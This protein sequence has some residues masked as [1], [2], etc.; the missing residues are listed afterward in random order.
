MSSDYWLNRIGTAASVTTPSGSVPQYGLATDIGTAPW[1]DAQSFNTWVQ[2]GIERSR[3]Q[4]I[5]KLE[6]AKQ[7]AEAGWWQ[8]HAARA[9]KGLAYGVGQTGEDHGWLRAIPVVGT[10]LGAAADALFG[11]DDT[12]PEA[13]QA[14]IRRGAQRLESFSNAPG[15]KQFGQAWDFTSNVLETPLLLDRNTRMAKNFALWFDSSEWAQAWREAEDRSIGQAL[16]EDVVS[17]PGTTQRD[18]DRMRRTNSLYGLTTFG[19]D[20]YASFKLDPTVI[21]A[22]GLGE[23]GRIRAGILPRGQTS[24]VAQAEARAAVQA[25]NPA[26]YRPDSLN[27][28][29]HYG[30]WRGRKV[31]AR[32]DTLREAAQKMSYTEFSRLPMF[33]KRA[34]NG[35]QA[36]MA[37]Q[38]AANDDRLWDLTRRAVMA[39]PEAWAEINALKH[40]VPSELQKYAGTDVATYIDAIEATKTRMRQLE[41]EVADLQKTIAKREESGPQPLYANRPEGGVNP[42]FYE[43]HTWELHRDLDSKVQDIADADAALRK[44]EDYATWLEKVKDDGVW[45]HT[46]Q[47][48]TRGIPKMLQ[49]VNMRTFQKSPYGKA[50]QVSEIGKSAWMFKANPVDLHRVDTGTMSIRRQFDQ[51]RHLFGYENPAAVEDILTRFVRAK[52]P[53]ERYQIAQEVEDEHL[54]PAIARWSRQFDRRE[55]QPGISEE[56][57]DYF[58]NQTRIRRNDMARALLSGEGAVYSTVPGVDEARLL[59]IDNGIAEVEVMDGGK[60]HTLR[61]PEEALTAHAH[62]AALPVDPTQTPNFYTPMDTRQVKLAIKRDPE[63]WELLDSEFRNGSRRFA[64]KTMETIDKAGTAWNSLWKPLQLFRLAWP[65]RVLLDESFRAMAMLGVTDWSR[66]FFPALAAASLNAINP[67]LHG[68]GPFLERRRIKIGKGPLSDEVTGRSYD[69]P[70]HELEVENAPFV[71][72]YYEPKFNKDR[73]AHIEGYVRDAVAASAVRSRAGALLRNP[74]ATQS[75]PEGMT[76]ANWQDIESALGDQRGFELDGEDFTSADFKYALAAPTSDEEV[77]ASLSRSPFSHNESL[78]DRFLTRTD[79]S[80]QRDIWNG[81]A[82]IADADLVEAFGPGGR[83]R[84]K[85]RELVQKGKREVEADVARRKSGKGHGPLFTG[86]FDDL[87]DPYAK[88]EMLMAKELGAKWVPVNEQLSTFGSPDRRL[89]VRQGDLLAGA[90]DTSFYNAVASARHKAMGSDGQGT[91]QKVVQMFD[92]HNG[93]ITKQGFAVRI[94]SVDIPRGRDLNAYRLN[95][96]DELDAVDRLIIQNQRFLSSSG[97]RLLIEAGGDGSLRL[98]VVRYFRSNEQDKAIDFARHIDADQFYRLSGKGGQGPGYEEYVRDRNDQ[99]PIF[100]ELERQFNW[101]NQGPGGD[102]LSTT[103]APSPDIREPVYH[104]SYG[105]LPKDEQGDI[106]LLP[107]HEAPIAVGRVYGPGFYTSNDPALARSYG[108]ND[109][110]HLYTIKGTHNGRTYRVLNLDQDI[111]PEERQKLLDGFDAWLEQRRGLGERELM[112]TLWEQ[113]T[114]YVRSSLEHANSWESLVNDLAANDLGSYFDGPWELRV[115]NWLAD[116]MMEQGYGA[117][118]ANWGSRQQ[119]YIWLDPE[120]LLVKPAYAK[121]DR[122]YLLEEWL[123]HPDSQERIVNQVPESRIH[124]IGQR[125]PRFRELETIH[126]ARLNREREAGPT[127][128]QDPRWNALLGR[129]QKLMHELGLEYSHNIENLNRRKGTSHR[130]S[131]HWW[132]Q[133]DPE[134]LLRSRRQDAAAP[135]AAGDLRRAEEEALNSVA[136]GF[137]G[138]NFHIDSVHDAFVRK[139]LKRREFGKGYT[140]WRTQDGKRVTAK[141]IFEGEGEVYVPLIS[142]SPTYARLTD[143]YKRTLSKYRQK[144]L[145]YKRIQ[146]PDLAPGAMRTAAGKRA[147]MEYY[148]EWANLLNDQI[149]NS[150]IW[151]RM[152][153]GQS[154]EQILRWLTRTDE[155]ARLRRSLPHKGHNPEKWVE[156]HRQALHFYLPDEELQAVLRNRK[157]KPSDLRNVDQRYMPEIFGPDLEMIAGEKGWGREIASLVDKVYHALGTVPTDLLSRQPFAKAMYDLKMR[158]LIR[159]TKSEWLT[160]EILKDY[161]KLSREFAIRQLRKTLFDLSDETNFTQAIRFLSPFWGAQQEAMTKWMS[162]VAEHPEVMARFYVGL[163]NIYDQM[164]VID[165][166]GKKVKDRPYLSYNSNDRIILQIPKRLRKLPFFDKALKDF[167][168]VGVSFGSANAAFQGENWLLPSLGPIVTVPADKMANAMWDTN[169]AQY[170]DNFFY[171]W[172]FP[173]GRPSG[174]VTGIMEQLFPGWGRRMLAMQEGQDSRMYANTWF[175]VSREMH[176]DARRRGL[177]PPSPEEV[178]RAVDWHFGLRV[179]ASFGLPASVEWRPKHQFFLDEY[180]KMQRQFGP[181]QAFEKFVQKYGTSAAR[182]AASSSSGLVPPTAKGM[183]EWHQNK[184]LIQR[185]TESGFGDLAAAVISPDAWADDFSSDSYAEQFNI[186]LG[187][188]SKKRLRETQGP[189]EREAETDRRVGWIQ[190]RQFMAGVNAELYARGLTSL[191]QSGAEDLAAMKQ[192]W[193]AQQETKNPA[194]SLDYRTYS[195]TIYQRVSTLRSFAFNPRFDSRPDIQGLRQYLLIR[196]ATA[197]SLDAWAAQ[198]GSRSLQAD[199][200]APLRA[201]FY[202]QVGQLIQQNPAFGEFYSRFLEADRLERGSGP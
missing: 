162:I 78:I 93:R 22:K 133:L 39:D 106:R 82:F 79:E 128:Y 80:E 49:E 121:D 57:I 94:A 33:Y 112:R 9:K 150:P 92:P 42:G 30:A 66:N 149:R 8:Q 195:D 40:S 189:L 157:L 115:D 101:T 65:Q 12:S 138:M 124:R 63:L 74:N 155:G 7:Q 202:S 194:W 197:Q 28:V 123:Q 165:E 113:K 135:A 117:L 158:N 60:R 127:H 154:D 103:P 183:E 35:P 166:D 48:S 5:A 45:A 144:A 182:Y 10:Y 187:P 160:P 95:S 168:A 25:K 161:E 108:G 99:S 55:G 190:Y 68:I 16:V 13:T 86:V 175:T 24:K 186:T 111:S 173:V 38:I 58:L 51:F 139:L 152:L 61:L 77:L 53:Y 140:T 59:K 118:R 54:I 44:H 156:E 23:A 159:S 132:T 73:A 196:D 104:G 76:P 34:V 87:R 72:S 3:S 102:E 1:P 177:P 17:H 176:L 193:V 172:L 97:H 120:N 15:V 4:D 146:P 169:G 14:R 145:G 36:A 41:D 6:R 129:E 29:A 88:L 171:R 81:T 84:D 151:Y 52:D 71:P 114:S 91:K 174:G 148:S 75:L 178:Q 109:P 70:T 163:D 180:H 116:W 167:G 181:G 188:G 98:S 27:P 83:L 46:D 136:D 199:E 32:F 142:A 2:D 137:E 126:K 192:Q 179:L 47:V 64:G 20:F 184:R 141:N 119:V 19:V 198:G 110:D 56:A 191:D 107:R 89:A 131:E 62:D 37:F 130:A 200:N 18:L 69:V 21:G 67:T 50:H 105:S 147:A 100:E 201:W 185:L 153:E 143:T 122:F 31:A 170:D 125:D 164:V 96:A 134:R 85:L 26:E 90:R 11:E 43:Y